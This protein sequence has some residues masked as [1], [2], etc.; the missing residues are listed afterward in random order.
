MPSDLFFWRDSKGL[1]IDLLLERGESLMPIE[2]KSGAN[3]ASDF[4]D[5]SK[6]WSTLAGNLER[7]VWLIYGGDRQFVIDSTQIITW[8]QRD[9]VVE[10]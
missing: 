4:K 2:I 7:P 3:I 5:N 10:K 6:K 8:S 1:E 9:Q